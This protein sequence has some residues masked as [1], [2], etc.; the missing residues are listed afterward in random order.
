MLRNF[1]IKFKNWGQWFDY[2][3]V[4]QIGHTRFSYEEIDEQMIKKYKHK[5]TT[6]K[7]IKYAESK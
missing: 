2:L 5:T 3:V 1:A 7:P 6:A 4:Y